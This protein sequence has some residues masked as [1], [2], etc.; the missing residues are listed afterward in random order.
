MSDDYMLGYMQGLRQQPMRIYN[1]EHADMHRSGY[2]KGCDM[3][4]GS[5][6]LHKQLRNKYDKRN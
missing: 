6:L 1:E 3:Y 4:K 2:I 5:V